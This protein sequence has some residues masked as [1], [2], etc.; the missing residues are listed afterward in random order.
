MGVGSHLVAWITD[1]LT[2]R[3]QYVRLGDCT[4]PTLWPAAQ[5]H[6]RELALSGPVQQVVHLTRQSLLLEVTCFNLNPPR[7]G[8]LVV[9]FRRPRPHP[10][11]VIIKGD[12]VEVVHTYTNTWECSWMINWTGLPTQTLQERTATT[13]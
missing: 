9:D 10:E 4:G 3:P 11:P 5:E 13:L 12:C 6:R 2:G 1:Y 7:P 8:S